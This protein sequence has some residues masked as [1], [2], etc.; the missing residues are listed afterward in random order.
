M[1][2]T[3]CHRSGTS[4]L[5]SIL[6]QFLGVETDHADQMKP[7]LDNPR[8]FHESNRLVSFNDSLL[9]R[10]GCSW[11]QPPLLAPLW[12]QEPWIAELASHRKRFQYL[13]L[14][15]VWLAKDPR[16]CLTYPAYVHL[17][18]RRVP[19]LAA[20]REPLAVSGSLFARNG[21][22][23]NAGLCIWYLYNHHLASSLAEDEPVIAYERLLQAGGND[24]VC[25]DLYHRISVWLEK[26]GIQPGVYKLWSDIVEQQLCPN[27]DRAGDLLSSSVL[28][29]VS[30]VLLETC[31]LAHDACLKNGSD[32]TS[33][34]QAFGA[35][36]R[37]ILEA[38]QSF[39]FAQALIPTSFSACV[40]WWI[41]LIRSSTGWSL[42][43]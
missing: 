8:G 2:V 14:Q 36:P 26:N 20:I 22:P 23:V 21:L 13:A 16:L 7:A 25:S 18:L 30:P 17:L 1:F 11:D 5:A 42:G 10:L 40:S 33:L 27:L 19:L 29:K 15:E 28:A 9:A 31:V 37:V 38:Q 34:Q 41:P 39:E 32:G 35:L 3:G 4:L 6:S 12:D 24:A 43:F